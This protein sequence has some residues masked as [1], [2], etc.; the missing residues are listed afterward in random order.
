MRPTRWSDGSLKQFNVF[1]VPISTLN[2]R[3][4][5]ARPDQQAGRPN[6]ELLRSGLMF[7][8]YEREHGPHVALDRDKFAKPR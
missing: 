2:A 5:E 1:E 3:A 8:L 7:W 6:Q 4:L